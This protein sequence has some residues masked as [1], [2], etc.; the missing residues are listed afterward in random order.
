MIEN[1]ILWYKSPL[2]WRKTAVFEIWT[3]D[4]IDFKNFFP[5]YSFIQLIE[6]YCVINWV[7]YY[8]EKLDSNLWV[9]K[10][11]EENIINKW[12]IFLDEVNNI[13][14]YEITEFR[15]YFTILSH[16]AKGSNKFSEISTKTGFDKSNLTKYLQT[17]QEIKVVKKETPILDNPLKSKKWLYKIDDF[18]IKFWFTFIWWKIDEIE[19]N[20][21]EYI[22]ELKEK[23]DYYISQTL[24]SIIYNYIRK[25]IKLDF[26][27]SKIW[28]QWDKNYEFDICG[29]DSKR[30]SLLLWEIKW[31]NKKIDLS[32]LKK[33]KD[34]SK[35]IKDFKNIVF[36]LV[37]KNW[38]TEDVLELESKE[39]ILLDI[40]K[41]Q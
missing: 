20:N 24:D 30:E 36:I 17:L 27:L 23:F 9:I 26:N 3:F 18:F 28:R 15:T 31:T 11:I 5:N 13:L 25:K 19:F 12:S 38:F 34:K 8:A 29:F 1:N 4:I 2:Y 37:S 35:Y 40:S 21:E 10:N 41:I 39:L 6:I 14:K 32:V 16:I 33:I 7:P 22:L